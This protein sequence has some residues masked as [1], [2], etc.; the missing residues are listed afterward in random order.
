LRFFY[1]NICVV[2]YLVIKFQIRVCG[3]TL[4]DIILYCLFLYLSCV[5]S[6]CINTWWKL[7]RFFIYCY[8]VSS[9][10][11]LLFVW[12]LEVT[13]YWFEMLIYKMLLLMWSWAPFNWIS[14]SLEI[15]TWKW[16][17]IL[18]HTETSKM[19]NPSLITISYSTHW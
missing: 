6:I 1:Q 15:P 17:Y 9:M 18:I 16:E 13:N 7:K 5:A 4:F 11:V 12:N 2:K 14:G 3:V 19:R 10:D 8:F